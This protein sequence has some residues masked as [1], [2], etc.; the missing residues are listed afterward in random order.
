[1]VT[2]VVATVIMEPTSQLDDLRG[3][4]RLLRDV[5]L[6]RVS[7]VGGIVSRGGHVIVIAG[8]HL[9]AFHPRLL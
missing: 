9:R 4:G 1:M 2:I 7:S 3:L 5:H 6:R 8:R